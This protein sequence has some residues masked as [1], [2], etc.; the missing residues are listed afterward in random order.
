MIL[1][2][3][4]E[5]T[6][7]KYLV[8]DENTQTTKTFSYNETV[9]L[10][11]NKKIMNAKLENTVIKMTD[12]VI[13]EIT[14]QYNTFYIVNELE[15][16]KYE[17]MSV[18]GDISILSF[19][20]VKH[21]YTDDNLINARIGKSKIIISKHRAFTTPLHRPISHLDHR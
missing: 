13:R 12:G 8:F 19:D 9:E 21:L 20:A 14:N 1:L 11:I 18:A 17:M 4:K 3:R 16:G 10:I 6:E 5:G 7:V 2:G 15:N